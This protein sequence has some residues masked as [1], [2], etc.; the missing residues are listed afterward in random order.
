MNDS[1][2]LAFRRWRLHREPLVALVGFTAFAVVVLVKAAQLLEP[3]DYAYRASIV[4]LRSGHILLTNAQYLSLSHQLG[5]PGILQWH[6]L[7]S[8]Q[9]ISEKNPGYP[10]FALIFS[11]LGSLRLAPLFYGALGGIG[12][13]FGARAWLGRW[14]GAIAVWIYFFSGAALTFA[15]RA[16][17]PSFTDAS[18]IAAGFGLLLWVA[19]AEH[20]AD[21]RRL[22]V[23]LAAFLSLEGAVF[24][25][26]TNVVE[27][28][29][30]VLGVMVMARRWRFTRT[31]LVTWISSVVISG[32][33]MMLFNLWAYGHA[34]STGYSAGEIS[35]SLASF[36]PNLKG[37]P[38]HLVRSMPM[39]VIALASVVVIGLRWFRRRGADDHRIRSRDAAVAGFLAVGWFGLWGIYL[40][41]TWTVTQLAGGGPGGHI[42]TPGVSVSTV[43]VIRFYLPTIGL[44]ALL[45]TWLVL[46]A[47]RLLRPTIIGGL[48]VAAVFSFQAMV[49]GGLPANHSAP[50]L[51]PGLPFQNQGSNNLPSHSHSPGVGPLHPGLG[52]PPPNGTTSTKP[53][54]R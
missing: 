54:G 39:L 32:L 11:L 53:N 7:T 37:M 51:Q 4:A 19:L 21:R 16:T 35:F 5:G 26:Y 3:D 22:A 27:V 44:I 28:A 14:A 38:T 18:L 1:L 15:W 46:R 29:V 40:F 20:I 36:W 45:A 48:V 12:I 50:T 42:G 13:F 31:M 47:G 49:S 34:T 10:F 41:Y 52:G 9:W 25:R 30:A 23:G 24:I 8:G 43:H 6:H 2:I 33:L 17:M